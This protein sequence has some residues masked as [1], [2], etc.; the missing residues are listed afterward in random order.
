MALI[1]DLKRPFTREF[2]AIQN[3]A[4]ISLAKPPGAFLLAMFENRKT[5]PTRLY[6]REA[7][8][9][10]LGAAMHKSPKSL[11]R[12]FGEGRPASAEPVFCLRVHSEKRKS[13]SRYIPN[14]PNDRA[15]ASLA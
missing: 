9:E 13:N 15:N 10:K 6:Q 11:M 7:G 12:M 4:K 3:F 14:R 5:H 1:R 2:N 8:F